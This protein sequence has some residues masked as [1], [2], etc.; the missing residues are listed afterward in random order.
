[1]GALL[2]KSRP[3][4][5]VQAAIK[6][7]EKSIKNF[8]KKINKEKKTSYPLEECDQGAQAEPAGFTFK[9]SLFLCSLFPLTGFFLI[10]AFAA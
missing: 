4:N 6:N 8:K 2:T 10:R 7:R 9:K 1:M 3:R 5:G